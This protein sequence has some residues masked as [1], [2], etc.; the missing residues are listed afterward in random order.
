MAVLKRSGMVT[1]CVLVARPE[2][3]SPVESITSS[4]I[5]V[6]GLRWIW[7]FLG[8]CGSVW[9]GVVLL[10]S[11]ASSGLSGLFAKVSGLSILIKRPA[12]LPVFSLSYFNLVGY[13]R[14][15]GLG[16][17]LPCSDA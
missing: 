13:H 12:R 11:V 17:L 9:E 8:G 5:L 1:V 14:L 10:G 2:V 7:L 4:V 15:P 6:T 16:G 3:V